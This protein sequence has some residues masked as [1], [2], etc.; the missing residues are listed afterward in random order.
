MYRP[1][2]DQII[3][4][5]LLH[6]YGKEQLT[7][8]QKYR[9]VRSE[10]QTEK[11]YGSYDLLS[12]ETGLWLGSRAGLVEVKKYWYFKRDCWVLERI[13]PN[14]NRKDV[15]HEKY[16]YEPIFPFLDKDNNILPLEWKPIDF[17]VSRIER[18]EKKIKSEAEWQA[19]DD[20]EMEKQYEK[21]YAFLDAPDPTK[22]LPTF[23]T[24]T[25]FNP[26]RKLQLV[27]K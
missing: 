27:G 11:R 8:L 24:S 7:E 12:E 25:L 10:D 17:L 2:I 22:P 21:T 18:A 19:E 6:I 13:E 14:L 1:S 3:N 15:F 26:V 4:D 20:K 23:E 16:T 9:V 5:R